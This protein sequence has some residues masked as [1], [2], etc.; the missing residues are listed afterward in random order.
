MGRMR[1]NRARQRLGIL[2]DLTRKQ[3]ESRQKW[4]ESRPVTI[5][6]KIENAIRNPR[7]QFEMSWSF[8]GV[9]DLDEMRYV[10]FD[11]AGKKALD[12][13]TPTWY[14][15]IKTDKTESIAKART[16]VKRN[17]RY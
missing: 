15:V 2:L 11:R 5:T 16:T 13:R 3:Q 8:A 17:K 1:D 10:K 14:T 7:P 6:D 9:F 4:L 12:I